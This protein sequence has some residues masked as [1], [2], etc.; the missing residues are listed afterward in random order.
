MPI[1]SQKTGENRDNNIVFKGKT[2]ICR[3]KPAKIAENGDHSIAFL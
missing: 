3:W 1:F 2:P